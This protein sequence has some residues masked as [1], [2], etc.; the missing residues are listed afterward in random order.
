MS[1]ITKNNNEYKIIHKVSGT[2]KRHNEAL[3]EICSCMMKTT[4][5]S[6]ILLS[7]LGFI[8]IF[9]AALGIVVS[10]PHV[11]FVQ[12]FLL[13]PSLIFPYTNILVNDSTKH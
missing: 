4:M 1:L 7:L 13:D 9:A 10:S 11:H 2:Y 3:V 12:V 5:F 8:P 6:I